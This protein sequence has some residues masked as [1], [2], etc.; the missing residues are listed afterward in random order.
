MEV[1]VPYDAEMERGVI[2]VCLYSPSTVGDVERVL[3]PSD[4]YTPSHAATYAAIVELWRAGEPVDAYA[5]ARQLGAAGLPHGDLLSCMAGAPV[6]NVAVTYAETI[7]ELHARRR[8]I[9]AASALANAAHQATDLAVA[10]DAHS[11]AL[12]DI[13]LPSGRL[14]KSLVPLDDMLD[15][16]P[17]DRTPWVIPGLLRRDWRVILVG[18]AGSGKSQVFQSVGIAAAQGRHP[19]VPT[20][21]I[22][23]ARV[24]FVD[25]ENPEER[26]IEGGRLVRDALRREGPIDWDRDRLWMWAEQS[27]IDVRSR[28]DLGRL[29]TVLASVRPDLVCIGPSYKLTSRRP[30]EGWDEVAMTTMGV[31]DTLRARHRFALLMEDHGTHNELRPFGSSLWL[32]WPEIGLTLTVNEQTR[33]SRDLGRFRADRLK[34]AWPERL[35]RGASFPWLGHWT[36]G[37]PE[38]ITRGDRAEPPAGLWPQERRDPLEDWPA[39]P[40]K[41]L[42]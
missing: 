20:V 42:G 25:L 34:N 18:A 22:P 41:D 19:F 6:S 40:R 13:A 12:G 16:P 17:A 36:H 28:R 1:T 31:L 9:Q 39:E 27:G 21:R 23:P 2:G 26:I 38:T 4:F 37:V 8:L 32:R 15:R 29:D 33:S 10:I 5:I 14:P 7:A 24:L 30:N 3:D 35:D 11:S